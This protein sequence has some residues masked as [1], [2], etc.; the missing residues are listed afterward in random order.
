MSFNSLEVKGALHE[1][2]VYHYGNMEIVRQ[3][4]VDSCIV[5]HRL[6][7]KVALTDHHPACKRAEAE[8]NALSSAEMML[9][10]DALESE[11]PILKSDAEP[12]SIDELHMGVKGSRMYPLI[13]G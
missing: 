11:M 10:M 1:C 5:V 2:G 3:C 13:L 7:R 4:C 6:A 8:W 9:V 12:G